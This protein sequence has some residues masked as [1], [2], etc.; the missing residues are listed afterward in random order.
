G[1]EEA[2]LGQS[3]NPQLLTGAD[4][5]RVER[6]RDLG[7][8]DDGLDAE[9]VD[10]AL[11][12]VLA[13][14]VARLRDALESLDLQRQTRAAPQSDVADARRGGAPH[15]AL[16]LACLCVRRD[17]ADLQLVARLLGLD[18]TVLVAL[19]S[20]ARACN[21]GP[22]RTTGVDEAVVLV[23]DARSVRG[24]DEVESLGRRSI[25]GVIRP[26]GACC[27]GGKPACRERGRCRDRDGFRDESHSA[28]STRSDASR[29]ARISYHSLVWTTPNHRLATVRS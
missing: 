13:A 4:V 5:L 24:G 1:V 28:P 15:S 14:L 10:G 20:L 2:E 19:A 25:R 16:D 3:R 12:V 26:R 8:T 18:Q 21:Q 27:C 9:H 6:D 23:V 22:R 7:P 11:L 29:S 17:R